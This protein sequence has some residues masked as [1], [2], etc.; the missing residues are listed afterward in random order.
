MS[1]GPGL[2]LSNQQAL[3]LEPFSEGFENGGKGP[4]PFLLRLVSNCQPPPPPRPGATRG[5]LLVW[6]NKCI[7]WLW[8][9]LRSLIIVP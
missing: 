7:I 3:P 5:S 2:P 1:Q 9:I 4:A 6:V 8:E